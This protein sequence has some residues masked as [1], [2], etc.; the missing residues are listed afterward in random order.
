MTHSTSGD[1]AVLKLIIDL[2]SAM[3]L[4][5]RTWEPIEKAYANTVEEQ[6]HCVCSRSASPS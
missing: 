3:C 5:F 4:P 2:S 6:F 1:M